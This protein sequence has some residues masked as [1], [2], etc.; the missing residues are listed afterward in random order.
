MA[1]Q[2]EFSLQPFKLSDPVDFGEMISILNKTC[3]AR[4]D[5]EISRLQKTFSEIFP[6]FSKFQSDD[7]DKTVLDLLQE[8]SYEFHQCRKTL[9][10]IGDSGS[11]FFLVLKGSVYVLAREKG[12]ESSPTTK[13]NDPNINQTSFEKAIRN[14]ILKNPSPL[15]RSQSMKY[16]KLID[17]V[18]SIINAKSSKTHE[19]LNDEEFFLLKYPDLYIDRVL[20]FGESFGEFALRHENA[21]RTATIV[22]KED[23]HLGVIS[24]NTFQRALKTHF[25]RIISKNLVIFKD[26]SLFSDWEMPQLEQ[27]Y[28]HVKTNSLVKNQIVYQEKDEA[29]YFYL[30]K[31]GEIEVRC[32]FV[33]L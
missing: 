23:C 5:F 16:D 4:S 21:K 24:K 9:F 3:T 17:K 8:L 10:E 19:E 6:F 33:F 29:D 11:K 12:L 2:R 18:K 13:K 26:H 1:A 14:S 28:H 30:I 15:A 32:L 7:S 27:F 31:D 22:C 25:D 20:P